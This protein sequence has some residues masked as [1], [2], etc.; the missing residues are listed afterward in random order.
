MHQFHHL[1]LA[2]VAD[3][4]AHL[5]LGEDRR[6]LPVDVLLG[7]EGFKRHLVEDFGE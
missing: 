6:A 4:V 7:Q 3:R 5:L 2:P 1:A